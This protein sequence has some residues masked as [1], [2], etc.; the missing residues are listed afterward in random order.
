M[1][2]NCWGRPP[3][4]DEDTNTTREAQGVYETQAA[5]DAA[6]RQRGG[7]FI[8][9]S[10]AAAKAQEIA[11]SLGEEWRPVVDGLTDWV[12]SATKGEGQGYNGPLLEVV[13]NNWSGEYTCYFN[14]PTQQ[15]LGHGRTPK[16]AFQMACARM[17]EH[18]V[19]L[20]HS[21]MLA[22]STPQEEVK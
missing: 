21:L 14:S 7:G 13:W 9:S 4:L 22:V 19:G 20:S 2:D 18:I 5:R 8:S 17:R 11:R 16:E 15:M 10:E 3:P 12:A 6:H 1:C